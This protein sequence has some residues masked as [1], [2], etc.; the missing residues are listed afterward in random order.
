MKLINSLFLSIFSGMIFF[1]I[2]LIPVLSEMNMLSI[3]LLSVIFLPLLLGSFWQGLISYV[4]IIIALGIIALMNLNLSLFVMMFFLIPAFIISFVKLK[5]KDISHG[6]ILSIISEYNTLVCIAV[7]VYFG[8]FGSTQ[9]IHNI[10]NDTITFMSILANQYMDSEFKEITNLHEQIDILSFMLPTIVSVIFIMWLFI[11]YTLAIKIAIKAELIE[12]N[13]KTNSYNLPK[14]YTFIFMVLITFALL[15]HNLLDKQDNLYYISYNVL[16]IFCFGYFYSG[17]CFLW[18]K[19]KSKN[20][21]LINII[22]TVLVVVLF[23]EFMIV[24]SIIGFIIELKRILLKNK[25]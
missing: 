14:I 19:V 22:Y 1:S 16:F 25:T 9:S 3:L 12:E 20:N 23:V 21:L 11:N 6:Y 7:L 4:P 8:F 15:S 18:D 5:Y 13:E 24:F 17:F 2:L 10:L